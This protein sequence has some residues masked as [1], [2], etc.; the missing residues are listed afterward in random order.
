MESL[1]NSSINLAHLGSIVWVGFLA[2]GII[3]LLPGIFIGLAYWWLT[4][5]D[6]NAKR[7]LVTNVIGWCLG[8]GLAFA[9]MLLLLAI[10]IRSSIPIF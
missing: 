6:D 8:M 1:I 5:P 2:G 10:I 9:G 3:G 4:R 7:L